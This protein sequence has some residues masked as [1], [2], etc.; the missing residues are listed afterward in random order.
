M[1]HINN[2]YCG[3]IAALFFFLFCGTSVIAQNTA[4]SVFPAPDTVPAVKPLDDNIRAFFDELISGVSVSRTL[5]TWMRN[6][7]TGYA[8]GSP[9]VEDVKT[10]LADVKTKFGEFRAYDRI[11][12]KQI[13]S[14]LVII[15]YLLKCD[16]RPVVWTFVFYRQP[17][18]AGSATPSANPFRVLDFR[19]ETD[20]ITALSSFN[21]S[22]TINK[23]S[24]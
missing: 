6:N 2:S 13:G 22:D 7:L 4:P 10:K 3:L 9:T 8:A 5:D 24:P 12:V 21:N 18:F 19:F 17:V 14:D 11:D 20:I 23:T 1:K 16:F 15:R